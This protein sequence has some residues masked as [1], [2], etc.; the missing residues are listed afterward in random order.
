MRKQRLDDWLAHVLKTKTYHLDPLPGDASFRRYYRLHLPKKTMIV[1]D[2]PHPES[3]DL[4]IHFAEIL[5]KQELSVPEIYEYDLDQGF[6]LLSDFG[7]RLYLDALNQNSAP[8]LYQDAI[9]A[10]IKMQKISAPLPVFDTLRQKQQL[11]ELFKGWYLKVHLNYDVQDRSL[12]ELDNN[13]DFILRVIDEQPKV[14]VHRDYHSRNL[15]ILPEKNPGIID[16]QD[17][18]QGGITYDLVSLFQDCY[19]TWPRHVVEGW[20]L[21][22]HKKLQSEGL[23][24]TNTPFD[25]FLRWFDFTGLQ[26][27]LKNLGVFTRKY[28]RDH[29][30]RYLKDL[31]MPLKY[32]HESLDRYQELQPLKDFFAGLKV[33][34]G[35]LS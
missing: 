31:P 16:F 1:M 15:M 21:D 7:D 9:Q 29:N 11:D 30:A 3:P 10:M 2:A 14:F 27:H 18:I 25:V 23:L 12:Q 33:E 28:H 5:I 24:T 22:V 13:L 17:A 35:T 19:I 34:Q 20:V 26:R 6:I 32:I 4:F 8:L